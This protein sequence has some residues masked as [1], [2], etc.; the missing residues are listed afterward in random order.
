MMS[1]IVLD[2]LYTHSTLERILIQKVIKVWNLLHVLL[3]IPVL[4]FAIPVHGN[5]SDRD[6]GTCIAIQFL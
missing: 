5:A 6:P 3:E 4:L 2:Q 1:A